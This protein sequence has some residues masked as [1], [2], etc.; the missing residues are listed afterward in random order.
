MKKLKIYGD[1]LSFFPELFRNF[2]YSAMKPLTPASYT[3]REVIGNVRGVFQYMKKGELRR[4]NDTL[5]DT[6][7][8]TFWTREKLVVGNFITKEDELYRIT[9]NASWLYE[10]GFNCYVMELMIGN[11]D[12]QEEYTEEEVD[13]GQGSYD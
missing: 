1:M 10:G 2:E 5:S 8:P 11:S 9:N 12:L 6:E 3:K 7:I 4:E 13:L